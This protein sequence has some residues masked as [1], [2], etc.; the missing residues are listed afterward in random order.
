MR[1]NREELDL[2]EGLAP[3][4]GLPQDLEVIDADAAFHEGMLDP[5]QGKEG[6]GII[7]GADNITI[8]KGDADLNPG[9]R[10]AKPPQPEY[11]RKSRR[12]RKILLV[13]IIILVA[14]IIAGCILGYQLFQTAN[15]AAT[16]QSQSQDVSSSTF[17]DEGAATKDASTTTVKTTTVPDLVSLLGLNVD[18]AIEVIQHGAQVTSSV[19]VNEEGNPIRT[20]VRLGLT[21]E[22][23]DTR[24]GTPTVYLSLDDNGAIIQS[25]YSVGT[26]ALGYG[27]LSF[28]DAITNE[29]LIEKTLDEAGLKVDTGS[30]VLPEDKMVYSSYASDGTTLTRENCS[31]EG[32]G[33]TAGG[34]VLPWTAILSYDYTTANATGNLADTIRAVYIYVAAYDLK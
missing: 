8:E 14:L 19:E 3:E 25:G 21:A 20:E 30:V 12:M 13:I 10:H 34:A 4:E 18:Q 28:S 33:T 29:H 17:T 6:L 22:P 11:M 15:T 27:S 7:G 24:S 26:S 5:Y 2:D 23:S 16:Q 31:F 1:R 9:G 32:S